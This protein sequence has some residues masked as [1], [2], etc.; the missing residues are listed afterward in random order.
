MTPIDRAITRINSMFD[1]RDAIAARIN[2]DP[3]I[4]KLRRMSDALWSEIP[5]GMDGADYLFRAMSE[6]RI[7]RKRRVAELIRARRARFNDFP[8]V[9]RKHLREAALCRRQEREYVAV[10]AVRAEA[11]AA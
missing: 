8:S 1:E 11:R 9:V 5:A 3:I 6:G 2:A 10:A 7:A 4:L